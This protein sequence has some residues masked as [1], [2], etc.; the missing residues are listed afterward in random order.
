MTTTK[1]CGTWAKVGGEQLHFPFSGQPDTNIRLAHPNNELEYFE[2]SI[3]PQIVELI[4]IETICDAQQFL[5]NM[6]NE[7][8]TGM[9]QQCYYHSFCY[10]EL[11]RNLTT[12][13][14]F[15]RGKYWQLAHFG[16]LCES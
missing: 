9:T 2:L 16:T 10:K 6:P 3:T 12:N 1:K 14:I 13:A 7:S 4:S 15:P 11:T 8:T 5:E